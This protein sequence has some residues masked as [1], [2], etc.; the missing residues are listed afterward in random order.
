MNP[1]ILIVLDGWGIN[2]RKEGNAI[3]LASP[4][5]FEKI[6]KTYPHTELKAHGKAVGLPK[7]MLGG[8]EVGHIHLGAGRVVPQELTQINKAI[9]NG[10]FFKNKAILHAIRNVKK[11]NTSLHIIGLLSDAGVHSHISHFYALLRLAK[12]HRIDNVF[13]HAFLDGRDTQPKSAMK[14][15]R[16][17]ERKIKQIGIGKIASLCGRYYAMD[18]DKRWK[19]V[20]LAYDLLTLG[21]GRKVTSAIEGVRV[22]YRN[23]ETDEFVRPTIIDESGIVKDGDSII[24]I[25]F[26]SDRARQLTEALIKKKFNNFKREKRPRVF[27]VTLTEYEKN[28]NVKVAF[29]PLKIHNTIGEWLSRLGLK[30]LRIAET[31]KYAHVTYFFSGGREKPFKGEDRILVPSP[32][33]STYDKKPEMSAKKIT[34][35]LLHKIKEYDFVLV[36]FANPDMV[37]HTGNLQATIKSIK[38]VDECIGKIIKEANKWNRIVVLVGDHGNADQMIDYKT[39][40]PLTSHTFNPVPF[41]ILSEERNNIKLRNGGLANVAPT[42]LKLMGLKKPK[43]MTARSLW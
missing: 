21:R 39:K 6:W 17:L 33:V 14:Y 25:N 34:K 4:K 36:N 31:E 8:S 16:A 3:A 42:L 40:K 37:G 27:F 9:R 29:P 2:K 22:A 12:K 38:V 7:G 24:F 32:K 10:D 13:I 43:E 30:Q 41:I 26:R 23:G 15:I 18:R 11:N 28:L 19:R 5:N 20:K 1:L 35:K